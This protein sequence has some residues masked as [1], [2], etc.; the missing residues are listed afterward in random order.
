[1]NSQDKHKIGF[2]SMILLG[3]NGIIGSGIF[4][5]PG[6]VAGLVSEKSLFVYGFVALLVLTIAWCFA[7]CAALFNRNGGAYL[8]VREAFGDFMGFPVDPHT[9]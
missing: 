1:M 7:Q 9:I 5:L 6:K 4:L 8:Y 3:I 2:G